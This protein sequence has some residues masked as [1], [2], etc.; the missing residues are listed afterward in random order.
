MPKILKYFKHFTPV[1]VRFSDLDI[2]G[3]LNN[4]KYQTFMEEAR[5]AHFHD[6]CS[7][8]KSCLNFNV[9]MSK[10]SI[11]FIKPIEFGDDII[12]Y[13]RVFNITEH[14]HEVHQVFVRKEND[15]K[16]IVATAQSVMAAFDYQTKQLTTFPES[17][18]QT[19]RSFEETGEILSPG[20]KILLEC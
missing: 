7:Q 16:E 11:D 15:K 18:S 3:H 20:N 10:I 12:I 9:V 19:I 4:A 8:H 5:I 13:T 2:A 14:S 6:V 17:Y 1:K